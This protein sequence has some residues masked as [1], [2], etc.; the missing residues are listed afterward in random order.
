MLDR[1]R[2]SGMALC[3]MLCAGAAVLPAI[4]ARAQTAPAESPSDMIWC[5]DT[6]RGLVVRKKRWRCT[7]EVVGDAE[8]KRIGDRRLLRIHKAL[9]GGAKPAPRGRS[10]GTGSGF[11]VTAAGHVVTNHH[12]IDGCKTLSVTPAGG[13]ASAARLIAADEASD[14]AL[15]QSATP[16]PGFARFREPAPLLSGD[17]VAV[18]GYPLHGRIAIKPILVEGHVSV[19]RGAPRPEQFAMKIDVRR[20]N[21][22]GPILDSSGHVVGVVVAKVNTPGVYASTGKLIRDLG[23]GIRQSVTLD[24][25]KQH[26]ISVATAPSHVPVADGGMMDVANRFVAQI[27]CWR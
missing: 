25:L 24:F 13:A 8:A 17:D 22:G 11:F 20:G 10:R 14:L 23:Y 6:E 3:A 16:S 5:H 26:N 12:V 18:V 4:D 1:K 2:L 7:G 27:T 21:S 15:L 19:G 9:Q